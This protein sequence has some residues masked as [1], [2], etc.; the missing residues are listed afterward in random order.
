MDRFT[1][2][3]LIALGA[4]V[5]SLVLWWGIA[6][7]QPQVWRLNGLLDDEPAL[8]AFSYRFRVLELID[9]VAS[10][11]TPRTADMPATRFLGMLRPELAG[12]REDDAALIAAE[13]QLAA[14]QGRARELLLAQPEVREVR[15]VLDRDWYLQRGIKP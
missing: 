6:N 10:V 1:R 15:W 13:K 4:I 3:Y 12:R 14:V 8:A 2:N 9:G 5:G 7:W 11:T